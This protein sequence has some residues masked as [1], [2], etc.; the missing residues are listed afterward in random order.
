M[1]G[2]FIVILMLVFVSCAQMDE[3]MKYLTGEKQEEAKRQKEEKIKAEALAEKE[4]QKNIAELNALIA[5][6]LSLSNTINLKIGQ[7]KDE[8]IKILLKPDS[9]SASEKGEF[10]HYR[11]YENYNPQATYNKVVPF[12]ISFRNERIISYGVDQEQV[13]RDKAQ[14]VIQKEMTNQ[15]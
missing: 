8:V 13:E 14:V 1:K 9:V 6:K 2:P 11:L 7:K 10:W 15:K 3:H 4:K 5:S 12:K